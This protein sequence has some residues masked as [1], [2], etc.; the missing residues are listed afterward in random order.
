MTLSCVEEM[1]APHQIVESESLIL[2]P[3]VKSFANQYVTK[4]NY[5][6]NETK[7]TRI[8]VL[9]FD[10]SQKLVH[11]ETDTNESGITSVTLNKSMLNDR[12]IS[13]STIVVI[14]NM[15]LANVKKADGTTLQSNKSSLTVE[16]LNDYSFHFDESQTVITDLSSGFSGFPMIGTATGLNLSSSIDH[17]DALPVNLQI[18]YAKI[19]FEIQVKEGTENQNLVSPSFALTG[20]SVHNVSKVTSYVQPTGAT[21]SDD[22]AYKTTGCPGTASGNA[23]FNG[24][25][26]GFTFYVAE[27]RYAHNSE[28]RGIY[29]DDSW[30]TSTCYDDFKQ[31]YK[32]K[33]ATVSTG[34]PGTGLATYVTVNGTYKDY[35]G[36]DWNVNYRVYLG[37]DNTVN[38]EV[39]RNSEYT[40]ILTIKGIRNNDSYGTSDVWIDHRVNV[41]ATSDNAKYATITRETLVDAH[42]EVRPLRVKLPTSIDRALL[43][44]PK[45]P[46]RNG[47]QITETEAG[48]NENWIAIENNNGRV[49]DITQYSSNGKRK[50]FTTSLIKQ[51]YLENNDE[52][53]GIRINSISG[54]PR[55]G[56]KYI[57]L[58]DGD[59]AWI[60]IDEN[61]NEGEREA[62]IELVFYDKEGNAL[63]DEESF[64]IK[65]QGLYTTSSGFQI[66]NYE[67][68]LHTYDSQDLY[69]NPLTDYTQQGY[70]WGLEGENLSESQNVVGSG[71]DI[72]NS[73]YYDFFHSKDRENTNVIGSLGAYEVVGGDIKDNHG[74]N[75][76]N[77]AGISNEMTI[78]DMNTRPSSAIQYCLSKNKFEVDESADEKHK[79]D[80]HWYLPDVYEMI[81]ILN[82]GQRTFS[83]FGEYTYWSSQPAWKTPQN[84]SGLNYLVD[85]EDNARAVSIDAAKADKYTGT[86]APRTNQHRIRCAYSVEGI[87]NVDFSGSRAPE[88]IGAMRF[89][90]RAWKDWD[91]KEK[92]YFS[93]DNC[94]HED[95]D[96]VETYYA[97]PDT[98]P[99]PKEAADADEYFGPYV[100]GYGFAKD[101]SDSENWKTETVSVYTSNLTLYKWPGLTTSQVVSKNTIIGDDV[102]YALDGTKEDWEGTVITNATKYSGDITT[103]QLNYLD[104]LFGGSDLSIGFT[105][106]DG[107][108]S[109]K[110]K[111]YKENSVE[112]KKTTRTWLTPKYVGNDKV[113]SEVKGPIYT[114]SGNVI[115]TADEE[116]DRASRNGTIATNSDGYIYPDEQ[117]AITAGNSIVPSGAYNISVVAE[118][119]SK[120]WLNQEITIYTY[121]QS[122]FLGNITR[123]ARAPRY[124]Y[125]VTYTLDGQTVTYYKYD[126]DGCWKYGEEQSETVPNT[127]P[128]TD[129]LEMYGGNS[130]TIKAN[131]DNEISSV[132]IYFSSSNVVDELGA[133][134]DYLRFTKDGFTGSSNQNP[135]GMTYSGDGD[136]GTMTWSGDPQSELTF[137]LVVIRKVYDNYGLWGDP[138]SFQYIANTT[139]S[140]EESIIIDQID[141]R[142][143]KKSTDTSK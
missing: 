124:R 112:S 100:D 23:D 85:D 93:W 54:D 27:S 81:Q 37:K 4:A 114:P 32:P 83:D 51:L 108:N 80:V 56:Q 142:Y 111:Y 74:L 47:A 75:F 121:Q 42:F 34:T 22:Y 70:K 2:V 15:D 57:Q 44:L 97:L 40:N 76:T 21:A 126:K 138:T 11:I 88:G 5:E 113:E 52:K 123:Y 33:I 12:D 14:A 143:K 41:S 134:K 79:M 91:T 66:E 102:Y 39:D 87:N 94:L 109:P 82:D 137:K 103:S 140:K 115:L 61:V 122:S 28:L 69:T 20:Y 92:G 53:Y 133:G 119:S 130:F 131:N 116:S 25:K 62:I 117:S 129:Q 73:Y 65:Q 8:A 96:T 16:G 45:Y 38:F 30:L 107:V 89:Y 10:N 135:P 98:Y 84:L 1:D 99:F 118:K 125:K 95:A 7:I 58:F 106:G 141:V 18:L 13:S 55:N 63:P 50:Y 17:T 127:D 29:P 43:Y 78:I 60:Y 26:V 110:F 3:R 77:N 6:G 71:D 49:K 136:K 86:T 90:M 68:Y 35:R 24:A 128:P 9:F 120:D 46:D 72:S 105:T 104:H 67:E 101:P 64:L 139:E 31:Q 132:K 59:C 48:V 19:N 36:T